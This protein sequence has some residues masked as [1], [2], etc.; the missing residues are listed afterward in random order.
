ALLG[1]RLV[2]GVL[3]LVVLVVVAAGRCWGGR[4]AGVGIPAVAVAVA[5][6]VGGAAAGG[7]RRRGRREGHAAEVDEG[8]GR[9]AVVIGGDIDLDTGHPLVV[10]RSSH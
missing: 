6:A 9:D 3:L 4:R 10:E 8:P 5:T 7:W 1:L 2:V